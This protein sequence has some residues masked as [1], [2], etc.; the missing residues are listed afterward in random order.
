MG[1]YLKMC[2]WNILLNRFRIG[3]RFN[4]LTVDTFY[5]SYLF[6]QMDSI[7]LQQTYAVV[8]IVIFMFTERQ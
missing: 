2:R 8:I 5:A 1:T 7:D 6:G 4:W 3:A